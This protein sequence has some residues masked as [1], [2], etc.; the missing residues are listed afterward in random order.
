MEDPCH[1]DPI[2]SK[3]LGPWPPSDYTDA[4]DRADVCLNT[5]PSQQNYSGEEP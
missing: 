3:V 4:R 1:G 5:I 2:M